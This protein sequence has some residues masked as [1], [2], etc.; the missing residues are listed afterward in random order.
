MSIDEVLKK[1]DLPIAYL[2]Y[3][4]NNYSRFQLIWNVNHLTHK[5]GDLY[6]GLDDDHNDI[7]DLIGYHLAYRRY[8]RRAYNDGWK[9]AVKGLNP[10]IFKKFKDEY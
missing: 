8:G 9:L 10:V 7:W 6:T 3:F 4:E 1:Y 5:I 2:E